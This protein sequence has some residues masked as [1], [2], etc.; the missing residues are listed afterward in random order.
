MRALEPS[1]MAL[2]HAVLG[3]ARAKLA[4][5]GGGE[6]RLPDPQ[7]TCCDQLVSARDLR[8]TRTDRAQR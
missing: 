8:R 3:P 6:V 7:D 4:A 2:A 1:N 5:N